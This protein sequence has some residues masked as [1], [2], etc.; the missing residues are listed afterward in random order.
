MRCGGGDTYIEYVRDIMACKNR[1]F[2]RISNYD[3]L[4]FDDVDAMIE[5]IK[6]KDD[7]LGLCKTVS[8]FSRDWKTKQKKKPK[9]DLRCY[10]ELVKTREFDI[11]IQHHKYIWNLTDKGWVTRK[12]S[13]YTIGC[14]HM[15][16]GYGFSIHTQR[17]W[18]EELKAVMSMPAIRI[19]RNIWS[20]LSQKQ[21]K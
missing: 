1:T 2:Q 9:D 12:D 16:Q 5:K 4:I 14:I 11:E 18:Q 6:D 10:D 20:N 8:G 13:H 19:C 15:T 7:R 17:F 21:M 3:F